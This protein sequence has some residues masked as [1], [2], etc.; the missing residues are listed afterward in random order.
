MKAFLAVARR[1]IEEKRFVFAAAVAASLVPFVVS[2]AR[3]FHGPAAREAQ[4]W[5]AAILAT[6][7]G[8]GIPVVLGASMIAKEIAN[9]QIGFYFARPVP[10]ITL[11]MAKL[12]TAFV[13][14]SAVCFVIVLPSFL[15]SV[16]SG[17]PTALSAELPPSFPLLLLG[18]S[19][20]ILVVLHAGAI[21]VRS[22]SVFLVIDLLAHLQRRRSSFWECETSVSS[23]LLKP[24]G[25]A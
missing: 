2:L 20:V 25:W 22:R 21:A 15:S 5:T 9:R 17:A 13:M 16:I 24:L 18:A 6:V 12:V 4:Q 1:D 8:V 7:F 11:W 23:T 14:T 3:G 19:L 10:A